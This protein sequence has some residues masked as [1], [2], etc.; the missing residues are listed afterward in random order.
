MYNIDAIRD[1]D[2]LGPVEG[3]G[4]LISAQIY[5]NMI[6]CSWFRC[7]ELARYD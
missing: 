3:A 4:N 7:G 6:V 1:F 2:I 5:Y